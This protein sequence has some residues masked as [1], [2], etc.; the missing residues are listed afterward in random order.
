MTAQRKDTIV[1]EGNEYLINCW[2]LEPYWKLQE[3]P[4]LLYSMTT[5]SQFRGYQAKWLMEN[6]NL[7]LIE[8]Y[9]ENAF[10]NKEYSLK[11]II[12][13]QGEKIF[14]YWFTGNIEVAFGKKISYSHSG[15]GHTY[16][17]IS[18]LEVQD[19]II[20]DSGIFMKNN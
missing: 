4:I 13:N 2:P 20:K 14:A 12:P 6:G 1:F 11:D 7:Y 9:G 10:E 8:F 17:F 5:S 16:E 15:V 19:G 3:K 18:T